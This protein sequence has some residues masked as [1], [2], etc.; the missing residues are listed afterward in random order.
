[1]YMGKKLGIVGVLIF[2]MIA[3]GCANDGKDK[4]VNKEYTKGI[5]KDTLSSDEIKFLTE[6]SFYDDDQSELYDSQKAWIYRYRYAMK[7]L[8]TRY[9]SYDFNILGGGDWY[10]AS[11]DNFIF[12]LK[13]DIVN[14]DME[15]F[16][17]YM[18]K[19]G[20]DYIVSENFYW[21]VLHEKYEKYLQETLSEIPL[22]GVYSSMSAVS[23][24]FNEDSTAE[25]VIKSDAIPFDY[26]FVDGKIDNVTDVVENYIK[27]NDMV[28][29]NF[30]I[31]P[32]EDASLVSGLSS[33]EMNSRCI[34]L[35]YFDSKIVINSNSYRKE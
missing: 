7:T 13:S 27:G 33:S 24:D 26:L 3:S 31:I 35:G 32:V 18:D 22:I 29:D 11:D 12:S 30:Y 19:D 23:S 6:N 15:F 2:G 21:Y 14:Y 9:P 28:D 4:S 1:M 8:E 16:N 34:E 5:T 10:V 20:D 17:L 25:D